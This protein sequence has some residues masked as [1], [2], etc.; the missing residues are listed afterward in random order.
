MTDNSHHSDK[1]AEI[2]ESDKPDD[3]Q[4]AVPIS[5][6]DDETEILQKVRDYYHAANRRIIR[7]K[8]QCRQAVLLRYYAAK[9]LISIRE[10]K[11]SD[12]KHNWMEFLDDAGLQ[13]DTVNDSINLAEAVDR[14]IDAGTFCFAKL[15][16]L[17]WN[18]AL[19]RFGVKAPKRKSRFD[20][21]IT[22]VT[23]LK[24]CDGDECENDRDAEAADQKKWR[25][26]LKIAKKTLVSIEAKQL[27]KNSRPSE[28]R[29][30]PR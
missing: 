26:E 5:A 17:K 25:E 10:R 13:Y 9:G 20:Y 4:K 1:P 27:G 8:W 28:K 3:L 6:N 19:R 7:S 18:E 2:P 29:G 22:A 12:P 30:K 23:N 21:L 16:D 15:V 11:K 24:R 14:E